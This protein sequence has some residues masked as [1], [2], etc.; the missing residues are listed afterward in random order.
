MTVTVPVELGAGAY[1]IRI[2]SGL[3][4]EIGDRV[5]A[6]LARPFT[7]IVTDDT[8]AALHLPALET[9]L[10]SA[11]IATEAIVLTPGEATKSL[12]ELERLVD[13]LLALA[14]ERRDMIIV[15]GGGV[16]GDLAGFAA[17]VLRRGIGYIQVPTTLLAQ[18]DS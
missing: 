18:V 8:V 1:E 3:L 6:M 12:A 13:Q 7:V 5:A 10:H 16:I 2:G 9:A 17:S 15:F 14:V 4:A 11:G